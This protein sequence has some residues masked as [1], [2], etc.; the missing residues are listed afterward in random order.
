MEAN[1]YLKKQRSILG[2]MNPGLPVKANL[3]IKSA[4]FRH[5]GSC[6]ILEDKKKGA[7][8]ISLALKLITDRQE[9]GLGMVCPDSCYLSSLARNP[10]QNDIEMHIWER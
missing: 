5:S 10:S 8:P 4:E 6:R 7:I 9:I 2:K 3:V 1:G